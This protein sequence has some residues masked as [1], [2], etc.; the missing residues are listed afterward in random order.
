MFRRYLL[1]IVVFSLTLFKLNVTSIPDG[2]FGPYYGE[3]RK[4]RFDFVHK[5]NRRK[6]ASLDGNDD[7]NMHNGESYNFLDLAFVDTS[8]CSLDYSIIDDPLR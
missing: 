7:Y 8:P 5:S 1:V 2:F 3:A 4:P 6:P